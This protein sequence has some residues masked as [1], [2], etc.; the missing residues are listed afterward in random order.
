MVLRI[1]TLFLRW[2]QW[3][4]CGDG[5]CS[6]SINIHLAT[7]SCPPLPPSPPAPGQEWSGVEWSGPARHAVIIKQC[8]GHRGGV[9]G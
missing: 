6:G 7:C 1:V 4:V 9:L 5:S 2:W 8:M 3:A